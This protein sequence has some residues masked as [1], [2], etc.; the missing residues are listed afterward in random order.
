MY[1]SLQENGLSIE[2]IAAMTGGTVHNP[3]EKE[4]IVHGVS[5]DSRTVKTDECFFAIKGET[6]DGH[7]FLE[8]AAEAGTAFV[9]AEHLPE[10]F[11]TPAVLVENTTTALGV[12]ASH[13]KEKFNTVTVAVTGSVG[14]TT[15]KEFISAVLDTKYKTNSTKGNFNNE[16]GLPLTMLRLNAEERVQVLEM[17]MNHRGEIEYLS[18]LAKPDIAVITTIGTSHIE[19]LGS[20]ENIRDAKMEIVSGMKKGGVLIANADE[21]LLANIKPEGVSIVYAGLENKTALY[22]AVNIRSFEDNTVFDVCVRGVTVLQDMKILLVGR[23]N[24]AN[25]LFACTAGLLLGISEENIRTGLLAFTPVAMR[26]HIEEHDGMTFIVDCYNASP[27]SMTAGLSVLMQTAKAKKRRP[28]AVL[29]DMLE[30]G[31]VSERAH[32]SV[33]KKAAELGVSHLF[34]FGK[35]AKLIAKGALDTGLSQNAVTVIED[36]KDAQAAA[37]I[38]KENIKKDDAILFKASRGIALERVIKFL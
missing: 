1:F 19:H 24:V 27:E 11:T 33:G 28:V 23:H 36:T 25:A 21:P 29:G 15:T 31:E 30:L 17:G 18:G 26:Q 22:R 38:I 35:A 3:S 13:Y 32:L 4:L 2:E 5:L 8:K 34:T 6:F 12:L 9:V 37:A 20:R 7:I 16:I 14:K 10:G